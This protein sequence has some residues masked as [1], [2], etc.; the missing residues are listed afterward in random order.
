MAEAEKTTFKPSSV[1]QIVAI[2]VILTANYFMT[3]SLIKEEFMK[4]RAD[5]GIYALRLNNVEVISNLA[6][7][8]SQENKENLIELNATLSNSPNITTRKFKRK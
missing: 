4:I 7:R 1:Y 2:A 3:N 6:Q 5:I 8:E